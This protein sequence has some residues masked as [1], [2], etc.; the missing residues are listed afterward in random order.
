[1]LRVGIIGGGF[2]GDMHAQCYTALSRCCEI[3]GIAD[4]NTER[5]KELEEKF[6]G[7]YVK[8]DNHKDYPYGL[9]PESDEMNN[10]WPPPC[11]IYLPLAL[12]NWSAIEFIHNKR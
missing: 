6:R 9:V 8:I 3:K 10:V 1:M 7:F 4:V 2:T 12:R 5:A 11:L